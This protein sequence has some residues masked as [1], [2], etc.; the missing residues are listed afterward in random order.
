MEIDLVNSLGELGIPELRDWHMNTL[1]I[2]KETV[3]SSFNG[4]PVIQV[5][6]RIAEKVG[7]SATDRIGQLKKLDFEVGE[8]P[9]YVGIGLANRVAYQLRENWR[10]YLGKHRWDTC[11]WLGYY[12][13]FGRPF[14]TELWFYCNPGK[15][16]R[17]LKAIMEDLGIHVEH[18]ERIPAG[19]DPDNCVRLRKRRRSSDSDWAWFNR[20]LGLDRDKQ[21][22]P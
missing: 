12:S 6:L 17:L 21:V 16:E 13:E 14:C 10:P 3:E 1:N 5:L 19:D 4:L 20:V 18:V 11:S 9:R 22:Y 2:T 7:L 15:K 8:Y